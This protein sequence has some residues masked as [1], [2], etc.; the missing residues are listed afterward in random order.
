MLKNYASDKNNPLSHV[1]IVHGGSKASA[2]DI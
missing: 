1:A 2:I